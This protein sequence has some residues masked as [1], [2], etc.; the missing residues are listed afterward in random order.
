MGKTEKSVG[1]FIGTAL[2]SFIATNAD[3]L[4]VLMN[5]FTEAAMPNSS[6]KVHHVFIG[7]YLGFF[8]LLGISL[9]GYFISYAIPVEMLGF[10]G[11][12]PII[13]GLKGLIEIIIE[14]CKKTNDELP[15][16]EV[17]TI[18]LETDR[19]QNDTNEQTISEHTIEEQPKQNINID[20]S[21]TIQL[22]QGIVK[23]FSS[24]FNLQTLRI[25]SIT[26]A[27]SGDNIAIYTPLF[28]QASKWQI[29]IY[30]SIFLVMLFIWLIFSY[31]FINFRPVLSIA[32]KYS[33]YIVPVVFIAIGIYILITSDCF[34]CVRKNNDNRNFEIYSKTSEKESLLKNDHVILGQYLGFSIL[35]MLSLIGYTISAILPIKIFGLLGFLIIYFGLNGLYHLIKDLWKKRKNNNTKNFQEILQNEQIEFIEIHQMDENN[36]NLIKENQSFCDDLKQIIKVSLV[37]IAN[38][39]D[40][41]AIYVPI[42]VQS[43]S[44]QIIAYGLGFLFM[45]GVLCFVCYCFI[46]FPPIYKFAQKYAHFIS[47]FIFIALGIYILIDS[48]C[49]PWLIKII[50]T[51]K[52]T[53]I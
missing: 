22:K 21:S 48:E 5:F 15:T 27:N 13:L 6:I 10:L 9:I 4:V 50:R 53:N 30:I 26:L 23:Y 25:A 45:V 40:N 33:H 19:C 52:W 46:H 8:I 34:P 16:N 43:T 31:Y 1:E 28:A 35:L 51:G 38:G 20:S 29:S 12:F 39:N 17:F 47:P 44:W 7:Q 3:D 36:I 2:V 42:F 11:F 41:I 24:C 18:Q 14:V 37:T 32:Q 49:F